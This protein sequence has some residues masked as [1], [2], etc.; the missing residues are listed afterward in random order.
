M[1]NLTILLPPLPSTN[2]NIFEKSKN[3][4]S[5]LYQLVRRTPD[6]QLSQ[7]SLCD[8]PL[9]GRS[10]GSIPF[11]DRAQATGCQPRES[12][13]GSAGAAKQPGGRDY[14][15]HA[16]ATKSRP[17]VVGPCSLKTE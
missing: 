7:W 8:I 2:L 10:L 15:L 17:T 9:A 14:K 16:L 4:D 1:K 13:E 6:S 3:S 12:G 11:R 5:I